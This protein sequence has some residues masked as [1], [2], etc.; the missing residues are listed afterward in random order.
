MRKKILIFN[1]KSV[2][3]NSKKRRIIYQLFN[4]IKSSA[5]RK[6]HLILAPASYYFLEFQKGISN[7]NIIFSGQNLFWLN[8]KLVTGETPPLMLKDL[9]INYAILGHSERKEFLKEDEKI[10]NLKLKASFKAKIT[11]IICIG[12]KE[13]TSDFQIKK[14]LFQQLNLIF[15]G[16]NLK[17]EKFLI[18]YEPS[19]AIGTN[20][21]PEI[22]E[23]K[24]RIETINF[25]LERRFG[26]GFLLNVRVLYGGS[27][28]EKNINIF[29]KEKYLDGFLIGGLSGQLKKL[30]KLLKNIEVL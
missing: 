13:K 7:K 23:L 5:F 30:E 8:K 1:F 15:E 19:W 12:E 26:R 16:I 17:K 21:T 11:P 4:K 29:L 3:L 25:W 6:Y 28:N 10:I 22:E 2:I 20:L 14:I 24:K 18:A 27:V 9:K